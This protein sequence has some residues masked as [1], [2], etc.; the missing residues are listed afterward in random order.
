MFGAGVLC[1]ITGVA[2]YFLTQ[3]TPDGNFKDLR[4]SG[5]MPAKKG[6]G[7]AFLSICQDRR[8]WALFLI[9]GACFGVELTINNMAALYFLD[10]FQAFKSMERVQAISYAGM[11]AG[12]FGF[13]NLF[14]RT[15]GGIASDRFAA[16]WGLSARVKWLFV[17]VLCE[18]MTLM[19]FSQISILGLAI[20]VLLAF[21]L[22]VQMSSGATF[23]I[24]P[25]INKKALGSVAGIVGAGG[26]AGAVLA[27]FLLKMDTISWPNAFFI[28]GALV[29][30][31]SF[32]ALSIKLSLI[33][34]VFV[35]PTYDSSFAS[36][37]RPEVSTTMAMGVSS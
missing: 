30:C 19:L 9:Y 27:G 7:V 24:V 22:F 36:E 13:M 16:R 25:F 6:G 15:M 12:L 5:A 29:T 21:S 31:C 10:Y 23:A 17:V 8:V 37:M 18:G 11:I 33:S 34:E 35:P 2:Y 1:A 3:D 26:N 14:S 20:P 32:V 28:V 4:A